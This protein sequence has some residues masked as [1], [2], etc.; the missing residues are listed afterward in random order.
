MNRLTGHGIGPRNTNHVVRG[1]DYRSSQVYLDQEDR[2]CHIESGTILNSESDSGGLGQRLTKLSS[3]VISRE[4][5]KWLRS[6]NQ[7]NPVD[8]S[9][10]RQARDPLPS[11]HTSSLHRSSNSLLRQN[12]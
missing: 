11:G 4:W 8:L 12:E 10:L 5:K 7:V 2:A 6:L 9:G 3:L 1:S